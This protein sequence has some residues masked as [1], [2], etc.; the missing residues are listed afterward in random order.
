MSSGGCEE[1]KVLP[2]DESRTEHQFSYSGC[3]NDCICIEIE[4]MLCFFKVRHSLVIFGK[5]IFGCI[6]LPPRQQAVRVLT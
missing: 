6:W 4:R 1:N 3:K 2:G 5:L